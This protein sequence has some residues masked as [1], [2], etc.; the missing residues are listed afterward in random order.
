M[1]I[2]SSTADGVQHP[3]SL[4]S[5]CDIERINVMGQVLASSTCINKEQSS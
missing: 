5:L 2:N 1:L 4:N 3:K